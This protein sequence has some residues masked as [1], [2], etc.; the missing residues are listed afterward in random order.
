[1]ENL[2]NKK[3]LIFGILLILLLAFI[4]AYWFLGRKNEAPQ[5][6]TPSPSATS[7]MTQAEYDKLMESLAPSP[8]AT[9]SMTQAEYDKLM[10]S[11][12][13]S[14][15]TTTTSSSTIMTQAEYDKLME[16]LTPKSQES[17]K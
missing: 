5:V 10:K 8:N 17:P 7:T 2:K 13:P 11:L 16:S 4:A 3:I 9:S 12:A 6:L 1:M 14:S 15:N